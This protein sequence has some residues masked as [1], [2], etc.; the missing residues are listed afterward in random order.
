MAGSTIKKTP[1]NKDF[2][3]DDIL[4]TNRTFPEKKKHWR[5]AEAQVYGKDFVKEQEERI[6]KGKLMDEEIRDKLIESKQ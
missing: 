3:P 2:K 5:Q 4:D 1:V 6:A